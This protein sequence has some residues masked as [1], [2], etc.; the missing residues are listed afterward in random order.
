MVKYNM[1]NGWWRGVWGEWGLMVDGLT[2][3]LRIWDFILWVMWSEPLVLLKHLFFTMWRMVLRQV[4]RQQKD[5]PVLTHR[6]LFL[7]AWSCVNYILVISLFQKYR[8]NQYSPER[9]LDLF[10]SF[11]V[12]EWKCFLFNKAKISSLW[13]LFLA[14]GL[15]G[16]HYLLFYNQLQGSKR[17]KS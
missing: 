13:G 4:K 10:H 9:V 11:C 3:Q 7:Q 17:Q 16:G 15:E 8:R 5:A 2:N 6:S 12:L 1:A 14:Y